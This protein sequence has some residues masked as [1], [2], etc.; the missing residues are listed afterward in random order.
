MLIDPAPGAAL[1]S[2]RRFALFGHVVVI[3]ASRMADAEQAA[4]MLRRGGGAAFGAHLDLTDPSSV[5]A[6]APTAAYLAGPIDV[7]IVG[8]PIAPAAV[9]GNEEC[10][11]GIQHLAAQL[12]S[13]TPRRQDADLLVVSY[14]RGPAADP[15]AVCSSSRF[16]VA[17]E[18][19]AAIQGCELLA[20]KHRKA[21]TRDPRADPAEVQ[22]LLDE[23]Q[24]ALTMPARVKKLLRELDAEAPIDRHAPHRQTQPIPDDFA[25]GTSTSRPAT[26]TATRR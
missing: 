8:S 11:L 6:F 26:A 25:I 4:R 24:Y 19:W 17:L 14:G 9:S 15:P 13:A 7:M 23:W 10:S 12:L 3:G 22:C 16:A 21:D 18:D 20:R 5:N 1:D 2:A